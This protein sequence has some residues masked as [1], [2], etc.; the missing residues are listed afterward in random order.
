V[1]VL[2]GVARIGG[3]AVTDPNPIANTTSTQ[4]TPLIEVSNVAV[5]YQMAEDRVGT[6]KE[7]MLQA[8][9][10]QRTLRKF[11]AV[12]D[13]SF[14]VRRGETL[15]LIGPNGAG[16]TTLMKVVARVLPP[17]EGP[18]TISSCSGRCWAAIPNTCGNGCRS[19]PNGRGSPSSSRPRCGTTR[20]E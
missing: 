1:G 15:A 20:R 16:K 8:L 13:V 19:S 17:T 12:D 10:R 7:F 5:E 14:T 3:A 11:R 6:F 2:E 4:D 9:K 18:T